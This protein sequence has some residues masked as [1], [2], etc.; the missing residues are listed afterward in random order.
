MKTTEEKLRLL[1]KNWGGTDSA[2]ITELPASG[3]YRRYFRILDGQRSVIGAHNDNIRE[4]EAFISFTNHFFREGLPVPA[5]LA[6]DRENCIY[7]ITDLS[8]E[9]RIF[10]QARTNNPG[11]SIPFDIPFVF[12]LVC[13]SDN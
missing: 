6:Y 7:L 1:Y 12:T 3:S 2:S 9:V 11:L 13:R 4:N 10:K 8:R 5:V